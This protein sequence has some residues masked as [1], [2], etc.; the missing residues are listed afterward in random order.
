MSDSTAPTTNPLSAL[1]SHGFLAVAGMIIGIL[2][3]HL[4]LGFLPN[5]IAAIIVAV[6]AAWK[7]WNDAQHQQV[8]QQAVVTATA[9]VKSAQQTVETTAA[10]LETN[11]AIA[12]AQAARTSPMQ[13]GA[14]ASY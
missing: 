9:A 1:F 7:A 6:A 10:K 11:D 2:S 3:S 4:V 14:P 8:T 13:G 12:R 5:N